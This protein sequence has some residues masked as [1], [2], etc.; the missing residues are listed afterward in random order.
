VKLSTATLLPLLAK[1]GTYF[2]MGVDH[3]A[4]LRSVG[5]EVSPDIICA[6]IQV[7]MSDWNPKI[8]GKEVLDDDTREAAARLLAGLITNMATDR[9]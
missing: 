6:F 8:G 5:A 3:Y 9:S 4:D 2:K 1:L 7:K